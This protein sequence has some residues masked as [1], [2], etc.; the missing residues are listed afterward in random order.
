[1]LWSN[2]ANSLMLLERYADAEKAL[3]KAWEFIP[4]DQKQKTGTVVP[5]EGLRIQTQLAQLNLRMG[6]LQQAQ[7]HIETAEQ[8]EPTPHGLESLHFF[9]IKSKLLDQLGRHE[10]AIESLDRALHSL[11]Y[12]LS[13]GPSPSSWESLLA[14]WQHLG[15]LAIRI[16]LEEMGKDGHEKALLRA[17]AVKGRL[18][19]WLENWFAPEGAKHALSLERQEKALAQAKKWLQGKKGRRIIS[20]YGSKEGLSVFSI[21]HDGTVLGKHNKEFNYDDFRETHY[22]PWEEFIEENLDEFATDEDFDK[23]NQL[24][25]TLFDEIGALLG[26]A[27]EDLADGGTDLILIPHRLLRNIP[28]SHVKLPS[29]ERLSDIF[30][31]ALIV[32][33]LGDFGRKHK[34]SGKKDLGMQVGS[35]ADADGTLPFARA[36]SLLSGA[37]EELHFG[38]SVTAAKLKEA[39][40]REGVLLL[41]LH[42]DFNEQAPFHSTIAAADGVIPL[43]ELMFGQVK[44]NRQGIILGVCESGKFRRSISDEPIGF[45]TIFLQAGVQTVLAPAWRIDDFPSFLFLSK[46]MQGLQAGGGILSL[47]NAA[48]KWLRDLTAEGAL[49]HIKN[50]TGQ[51]ET[52]AA[53]MG[54]TKILEPFFKRIKEYEDWLQVLPP[55]DQPF[56]DPLEW[57]GF[58]LAGNVYQD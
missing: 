56:S 27:F 8:L 28:L 45:S 7:S 21:G 16:Y 14:N 9:D 31:T 58:F 46:I 6:N 11:N 4:P 22:E 32:P 12:L 41:S 19:A 57:A 23:A 10:E 13:Q 20:F 50:A 26:A 40:A 47:T 30:E 36:E 38:E 49:K 44:I 24:T 2:Y 42:G 39:V 52:R 33:S 53:A 15:D 51:I 25:D 29:G 43:H 18:T 3:V 5:M 54:L 35:L 48:A 1:V 34:T 55:K 17:E 37:E